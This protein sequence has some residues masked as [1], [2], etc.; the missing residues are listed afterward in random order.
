MVH[1]A[2]TVYPDEGGAS[3]V[4]AV[5]TSEEYPGRVYYGVN[6]S[7]GDPYRWVAGWPRGDT[8]PTRF[9]WINVQEVPRSAVE[10]KC[11]RMPEDVVNALL[12]LIAP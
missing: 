7:R 1:V 12:D 10:R 9:Y 11:G 6:W 3:L 8:T 2:V 5:G 4:C